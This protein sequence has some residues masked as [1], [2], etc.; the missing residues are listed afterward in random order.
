MIKEKDIVFEQGDFWV[1]QTKQKTYEVYRIG[2]TCSTRV[3]I[4]GFKGE[5]GLEIAKREI[6]RRLKV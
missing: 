4:I 2:A 1:Y 3:A 5:Q 6:E